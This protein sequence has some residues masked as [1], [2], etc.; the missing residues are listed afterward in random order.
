MRLVVYIYGYG[1]NKLQK[2]YLRRFLI[3]SYKVWKFWNMRSKN[4]LKGIF[5][6]MYET[7]KSADHKLQNI[8]YRS[9]YAN[10]NLIRYQYWLVWIQ[11]GAQLFIET[12]VIL[13][14]ALYLYNFSTELI[15]WFHVPV[16][17][18]NMIIKT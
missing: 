14:Y 8:W 5:K 12:T 10:F 7:A 1:W 11:Y 9:F 17:C 18:N 4:D 16:S 13:S 6:M 15:K 3:W 2:L